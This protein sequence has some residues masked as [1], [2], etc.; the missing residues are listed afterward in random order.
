MNTKTEIIRQLILTDI[1]KIGGNARLMT[2]KH[3][4]LKS[5]IENYSLERIWD[6]AVGRFGGSR[7]LWLDGST[8]C[9][10]NTVTRSGLLNQK[11][12]K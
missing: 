3:K 8:P 7:D 4:T 9:C 6:D 12:A 10:I 1:L 11:W 5:P 2:V